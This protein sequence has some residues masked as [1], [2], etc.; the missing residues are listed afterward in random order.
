MAD[1]PMADTSHPT[2]GSVFCVGPTSLTSVNNA[3]GLPGPG[4][5]TIKGRA[6]GLP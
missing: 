1:V 2:L 4:R 6:L 3:S 5:V